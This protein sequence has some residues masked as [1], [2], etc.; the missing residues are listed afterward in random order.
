MG[1]TGGMITILHQQASTEIYS[2]C[3]DKLCFVV[4]CPM[5]YF[6]FCLWR[7]VLLIAPVESVEGTLVAH[8]RIARVVQYRDRQRLLGV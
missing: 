1:T 5:L 4:L 6:V 3:Y 8:Q 7:A 2:L